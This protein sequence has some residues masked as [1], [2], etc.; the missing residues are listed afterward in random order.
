MTPKIKDNIALGQAIKYFTSLGYIVNLPLN[1]SQ[2]Y[3]LVIDDGNSLLKVQVK[4]TSQ[5]NNKGEYICG[6]R[7]L[8][9]SKVYYVLTQT[10]CDLLFCYCENTNAYLI[11]TSEITTKS[12]LL[13]QDKYKI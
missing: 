3:D 10:D 5:T 4:Y 6:L 1:D 8:S 11:P 13:L 12:Q 7:T 2:N 9:G